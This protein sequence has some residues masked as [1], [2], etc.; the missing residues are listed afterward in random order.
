[1]VTF[2]KSLV[3]QHQLFSNV[4]HYFIVIPSYTNYQRA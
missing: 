4:N 3:M 1:M 2:L